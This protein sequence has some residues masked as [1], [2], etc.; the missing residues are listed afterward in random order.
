MK[1]VEGKREAMQ[2]LHTC[3]IERRLGSSSGNPKIILQLRVHN[4]IIMLVKQAVGS[5]NM[6]S[7]CE[8]SIVTIIL[9]SLRS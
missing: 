5:N 4:L 3:A 9:T 6:R 1:A 2:T 8:T 7:S